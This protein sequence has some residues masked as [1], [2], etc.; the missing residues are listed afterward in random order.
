MT[1]EEIVRWLREEHEKVEELSDRLREHIA[2]APR[3]DATRWIHR[4]NELFDEMRSCCGTHMAME[5]QDGYLLHV[6]ERRPTLSGRVDRLKA[7]HDE[8]A[9][10]MASI[11]TEIDELR[12]GDRILMRDCRDRIR[13]FL[14]FIE[15][16]EQNENLLVSFVFTQDIGTK[17]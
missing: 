16:H 8:L 2:T 12:P 13:R 5:E 3:G 1:A 4:L 10:L 15:E 11:R 17:D 7:D 6:L 14:A 9:R